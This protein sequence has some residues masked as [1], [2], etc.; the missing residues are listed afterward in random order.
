[1]GYYIGMVTLV[2]VAALQPTVLPAI[3]VFGGQPDLTL[4]LVLCWSVHAELEESVFWAFLG[5]ITLDL[6]SIT[7]LGTSVIGLLI[8]V[9]AIRS[10]SQ[11]LYSFSLFFLVGFVAIGTIL[12]HVILITV[13][14]STGYPTDFVSIAQYFTL[15]TLVYNV[16]L[17]VPVYWVLRRFQK[18][19]PEPQ[20]GF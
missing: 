18:R 1:M 5:G 19:I 6:L 9:F 14:T 12:Q 20:R 15:P 3:R 11:R 7:P 17:T 16:V 10:L 8:M 13:L 4:L 2:L